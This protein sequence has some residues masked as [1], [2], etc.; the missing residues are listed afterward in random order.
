MTSLATDSFSIKTRIE[1][2]ATKTQASRR[3]RLSV[4]QVLLDRDGLDCRNV[5]VYKPVETTVITMVGLMGCDSVP[6]GIDIRTLR[7][8]VL[9]FSPLKMETQN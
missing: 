8:H 5:P 9:P 4:L 6:S 2:V 1:L 7:I 3:A